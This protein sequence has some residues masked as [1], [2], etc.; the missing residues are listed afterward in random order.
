MNSVTTA[1]AREQMAKARAG[2]ATVSQITHMAFGNGGV[3]AQGVPI[4]PL[5]TDTGL[6]NETFRKAV[7]GHTYPVATTCR[8][9]CQLV[10][11]ELADQAINEMALIDEA[12]HMVAKKTFK[13]K[14]KDS[15]L[16]MTFELDDI[17]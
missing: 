5:T 16:K 7:D 3:N 6:N 14:V 1:Y 12:G 17:Y 2:D 9:S 11:S 10:E 13:N 8:Y 4:A 15:D